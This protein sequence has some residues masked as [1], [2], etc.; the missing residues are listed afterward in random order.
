MCFLIVKSTAMSESANELPG[1]FVSNRL[2]LQ[3]ARLTTSY[4]DTANV[5]VDIFGFTGDYLRPMPRWGQTLTACPGESSG[6]N[7]MLLNFDD[8]QENA[9]LYC[10]LDCSWN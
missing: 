6:L 2:Y 3:G 7:K 9:M 4:D 8:I 1:A 5:H 10:Q